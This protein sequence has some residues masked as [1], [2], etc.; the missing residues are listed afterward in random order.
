MKKLSIILA[1]LLLT[2]LVGC[3]ASEKAQEQIQEK[4]AEKAIEDALGGD[5]KVDIDGD[6]YTY[7]DKDGNKME[8]GSTEWP[9]DE[10]AGFI[11]KFNKGAI[12][13]CTIMGNMFLIDLEKVEQ[14]D[15]DSYLQT[16]KDAGFTENSFGLEGTETE[17]YYQYQALNA[18]GASMM[19]SYEAAEKKLQ[20]VGTAAEK[21]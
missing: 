19:L 11:P 7:E 20:I 3:G 14:E 9:S 16:V 5:V 15:Y 1:A 18:D 8:F 17:G 12:T 21:E 4:A 13:G 2:A 6:K 10:A